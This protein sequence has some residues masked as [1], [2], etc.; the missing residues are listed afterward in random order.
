MVRRVLIALA[1]LALLALGATAPVAAEA[2]ESFTSNTVLRLDGSV[3]VTEIIDVNAEGIQ[4]RRGIYRD[5][6]T[7]MVNEDN[8]RLRSN[9]DVIE[10]QRN[11]RSEP[12][13]IES[14]AAGFVRIRIG[15]ADV[16]LERGLHRYTIRYTMTRMARRFEDHDELYWNATGNYWDFPILNSVATVTLPEGAVI[17]NLVGYTGTVGSTEQAVTITQTSGNTAM[18]RTNRVLQRSEGLTIAA[19]FQ[20]GVLAEPSDTQRAIWWLSDHRDLVVPLIALALV[21]FYYFLAW[22]SVGRDPR[23]GVIIPLF[24]P[25]KDF[26]PALVHFVHRM[27][28]EKSGWTA[29]TA[30][31][32]NLGVKGLVI[33]DNVKKTLKVTVTGKQPDAPLPPGEQVLFD[34]FTSKGT[35]TVNKSNG[36]KINEKRGDF[37]KALEAENRQVYFN[38]NTGYVIVGVVFSVLCM[39]ALVLFDMLPFFVL[40]IA[41]VAGVALGLFTGFAT[42]LWRGN[43]ASRFILIVWAVIFFGNVGGGLVGFA[44]ELRFDTP[45]VAAIS[46]ALINVVFA[47]LM[48]AP[49]VQG[50]KIMDQI[51]GFKMYLETA[52][53]NRLNIQGEP[54]MTVERFER[55][56]PYAIALKV[57]KPWSEHFEA[58]LARNAVSD[59]ESG[60]TYHPHWYRGTDWSSAKGGFSSSVAS[61]ASGMS[62]AMIAAQPT[63][64]S[65]SGFS[66][67]GGGG[68]FSGGGGGGGGGGGW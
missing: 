47:V 48:R 4:I 55:I 45:L 28:W 23:K 21:L 20:K 56:L 39:G 16:F 22:N 30:A 18:F 50:R 64:S 13:A 54:P 63:Q 38:H 15:D 60:T 59:I 65:S 9:L 32:F 31:I 41:I 12:Y 35:L 52:E 25:P 14:L 68:G 40:M 33:I 58:E 43:L 8:S 61:V 19:A 1:A 27:G 5:I 29:F 3:E 6:P 49:T 17:S 66:G 42:S 10:V 44:S 57:E 62:A 11:G 37:V 53:K 36:A 51:E 2:I 34:Y 24:H 46:I 7:L 67:G 26:S